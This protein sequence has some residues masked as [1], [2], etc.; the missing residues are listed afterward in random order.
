M[1]AEKK[2]YEVKLNWKGEVHTFWLHAVSKANAKNIAMVKL[3][4]KLNVTLFYVKPHF[5]EEKTTW[6]VNERPE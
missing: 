2:R 3:A 6:E 4:Q 5:A 1:S